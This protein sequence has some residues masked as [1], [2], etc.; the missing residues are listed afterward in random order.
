MSDISANHCL[1]CG[2]QDLQAGRKDR[3]SWDG[4]MAK[5]IWGGLALCVVYGI[6]H[7]SKTQNE[8]PTTK[9]ESNSQ[10]A[11][12]LPS[13]KK[14]HLG[15]SQKQEERMSDKEESHEQWFGHF[16]SEYRKV[17]VKKMFLPLLG[18]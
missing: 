1:V 6:F 4:F 12:D 7:K 14:Q 11:N 8:N 13:S 16:S 17:L 10:Q 2:K 5:L 18:K 9:S 15:T 3:Q